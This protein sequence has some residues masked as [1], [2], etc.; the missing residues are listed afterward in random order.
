VANKKKKKSR[1]NREWAS[2]DAA[3]WPGIAATKRN[4]FGSM[5]ELV[6]WLK[7]YTDDL[8]AWGQDVRDDIIRLEAACRIPQGD[9]GDPPGGPP[10]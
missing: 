10:E 4:P 5:D 9:P 3:V 8:A 2:D 7:I 1:R 6:K